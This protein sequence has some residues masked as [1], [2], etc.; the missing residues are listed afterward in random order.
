MWFLALVRDFLTYSLGIKTAGVFSR[1]C[2]ALTD[3]QL[4]SSTPASAPS[5]SRVSPQPVSPAHRL[6]ANRDSCLSLSLCV[7]QADYK[8]ARQFPPELYNTGTVLEQRSCQYGSQDLPLISVYALQDKGNFSIPSWAFQSFILEAIY[9]HTYII[10]C[11]CG[12]CCLCIVNI[13][14]T[15]TI[16]HL[17]HRS[18]INTIIVDQLYGYFKQLV[19]DFICVNDTIDEK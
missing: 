4:A 6:P 3:L 5:L 13:L 18:E 15:I 11:P 9:I 19:T 17:S 10:G 14:I 16:I 2:S 8:L 1:I 12:W 7:V